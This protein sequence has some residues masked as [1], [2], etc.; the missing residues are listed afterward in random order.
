[1]RLGVAIGGYFGVQLIHFLPFVATK[2]NGACYCIS[3]RQL[4]IGDIFYKEDIEHPILALSPLLYQRI[5]SMMGQ[6]RS[7]DAND[8][9]RDPTLSCI[10]NFFAPMRLDP[11]LDD[12]RV[13]PSTSSSTR[14]MEST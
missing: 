10:T 14:S 7:L 4:A 3:R 2:I 1:M 5:D 6:K 13:I 8:A 9:P 12:R 11:T